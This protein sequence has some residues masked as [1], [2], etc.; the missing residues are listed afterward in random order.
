[1]G[2]V[3]SAVH[4]SAICWAIPPYQNPRKNT[5]SDSNVW[6]RQ[7]CRD[8]FPSG[9]SLAQLNRQQVVVPLGQ[10]GRLVVGNPIGLDL[11][12]RQVLRD[13]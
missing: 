11:L 8:S 6:R 10:F 12:R 7:A 9:H 3:T 13:V 5:R 1:M 4:Q 2:H